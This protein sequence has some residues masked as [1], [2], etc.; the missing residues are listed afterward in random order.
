M[1]WQSSGTAEE[2]AEK[3]ESVTS[4]AKAADQNKVVIAALKRC[5]TQN[6]TFSAV[7]EAVPLP[8][9]A[10]QSSP[11]TLPKAES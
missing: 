5:A 6:Q 8:K 2:A 7:C 1:P 10:N 4:A 3:V 11:A 9:P